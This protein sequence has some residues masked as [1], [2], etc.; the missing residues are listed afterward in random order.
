MLF[1][2]DP[3]F[4]YTV[5]CRD[6]LAATTVLALGYDDDPVM[7]RLAIMCCGNI[8]RYASARL[9]RDPDLQAL[10]REVERERESTTQ[11]AGLLSQLNQINEDEEGD[12]TRF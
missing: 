10:A 4:L 6:S 3:G 11:G 8:L 1:Y 5:M 7:L 12:L 2:D 9:R